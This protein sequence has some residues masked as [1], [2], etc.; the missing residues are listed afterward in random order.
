MGL[1]YNY[2]ICQTQENCISKEWLT[3]V[4]AFFLQN[5]WMFWEIH[6]F[7]FL[8]RVR[9]EDWRKS[10]QL[11]TGK[12]GK[13]LAWLAK[14][15]KHIST[16]KADKFNPYTTTS[17]YRLRAGTTSWTVD[18]ICSRFEISVS[19]ISVATP[20]EVNEILCPNSV[21]IT[22]RQQCQQFSY[23]QFLLE[24]SSH[25]KYLQ[26]CLD[27]NLWHECQKNI[28][29]SKKICNLHN[30]GLTYRKMYHLS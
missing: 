6:L 14:D 26:W 16:F 4:F 21:R 18:R 9:I 23:R 20:I 19:D 24:S 10:P 15:R 5:D 13:T 11:K 28:E 8:L 12:Q 29:S 30:A 3:L 1:K 7:A 27:N 22:H 17:F 25:E 2:N